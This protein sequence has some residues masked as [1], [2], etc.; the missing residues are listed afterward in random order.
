MKAEWLDYNSSHALSAQ[1]KHPNVIL[2]VNN[3]Q[4]QS[5]VFI[6]SSVSLQ[7]LCVAS[8]RRRRRC[9]S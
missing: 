5:F 9:D 8:Q 6:C 3:V 2:F 7:T 1:Q 4:K